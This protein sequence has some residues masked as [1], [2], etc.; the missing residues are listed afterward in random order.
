MLEQ[1]FQIFTDNILPI[2]LIAGVGFWLRRQWR[3]QPEMLGT[4]VLNALSPALV[5]RSLYSNRLEGGE[6]AGLF[7]STVLLQLVMA[8]LGWAFARAQGADAVDRATLILAAFC[9]NA[10]NYGLSLVSFAFNEEVLARAVVVTVANI[11]MN[12]SLGIYIAS[13]G[14]STARQAL[15][16][17]ARTPALYAVAAAF[18]VIVLN[19]EL[20]LPLDRAVNSL[21][22]ASIPMMLLVLGLQLGQFVRAG[23]PQMLL[24]GTGLKLFVA[25]MLAVGIAALFGL[26]D[27]G[28]TAFIVQAAM[29]TAVVTILF[30]TEFNLNKPLTLNLIMASTLASPF[31]LS[32]LILLLH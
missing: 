13:N 3:V 17:V 18:V 15:V 16:R 12:Y 28:R 22:D 23:K 19:I 14:R 6:V 24:A 31:T 29:P 1:L 32:V 10:G 21:A 2:L 7:F 4:I 27:L 25:P 9:L 26:N 11:T 30:A 8:A 20:P 5:F